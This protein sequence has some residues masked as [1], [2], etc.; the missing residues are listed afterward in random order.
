MYIV[1]FLYCTHTCVQD[2]NTGVRDVQDFIQYRV[3][4]SEFSA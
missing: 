3:Q 1:W 2:L 4:Y